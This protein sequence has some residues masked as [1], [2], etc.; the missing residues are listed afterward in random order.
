MFAQI[1][2]CLHG[3]L[4]PNSS[5]VQIVSLAILAVFLAP[6][7]WAQDAVGALEGL[8]TDSKDTPLAGVTIDLKNLDTNSV[9][10]QTSNAEGRYRFALLNVGRYS[11]TADVP[12]FA[13]FSQA[14]IE[15][16]V[17]QTV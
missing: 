8:V 10:V 17:S 11:L 9:R 5:P 7:T 15:I 14:P 16:A 4:R 12:G 1:R 13:H 2:R 3:Y 6:F